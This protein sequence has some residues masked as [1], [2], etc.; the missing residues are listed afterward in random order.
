MLGAPPPNLDAHGIEQ[1][2]ATDQDEE[3]ILSDRYSDR[4]S[5][6]VDSSTMWGKHTA[7]TSEREQ[8]PQISKCPDRNGYKS[9]D[10]DC[11]KYHDRSYILVS[12]HPPSIG[13]LQLC[14]GYSFSMVPNSM[15]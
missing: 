5:N 12:L 7:R 9:S 6:T 15:C 2:L 8:K 13:Y 3:S 4:H 11:D 10:K 14:S 1:S